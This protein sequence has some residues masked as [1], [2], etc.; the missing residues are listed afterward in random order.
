MLASPPPFNE[1]MRRLDFS[2]GILHL[3][4]AV[5][6]LH[7]PLLLEALSKHEIPTVLVSAKSDSPPASWEVDHDMLEELCSTITNVE[8]FSVSLSKP[9]TH[10]RCISII[11]RKIM[12]KKRGELLPSLAEVIPHV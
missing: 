7:Y 10:K 1:T 5:T 9:E 12:V 6:Y 8:P 3:R 11:L 4:L 2:S